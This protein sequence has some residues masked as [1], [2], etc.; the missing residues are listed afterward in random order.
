M[1]YLPQ[2]LWLLASNQPQAKVKTQNP[3]P[4]QGKT[5]FIVS[6]CKEPSQQTIIK[7]ARRKKHPIN[8]GLLRMLLLAAPAITGDMDKPIR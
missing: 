2:K 6:A 8:K 7:A 5:A 1:N 3:V 4:V